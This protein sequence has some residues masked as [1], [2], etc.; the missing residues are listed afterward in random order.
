MPEQKTLTQE[1]FQ[2]LLKWLDADD[3]SAGMKY[4]TIRR[5]L[6]RL[7]V[8]RGCYEA[9][10]LADQTIDRVCSKVP[11]VVPDYVGDPAI[12]FV[13]VANKIHLEWLRHEKRERDAIYIDPKNDLPDNGREYNCLE[14]C[15][16]KLPPD[17]R[18]II[19]EYYRDEKHAKIVRR[20][21]LAENLGISMGALQ[22]KASRIRARL[23]ICVK[24][25]VAEKIK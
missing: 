20:K 4:E 12:Y 1:N 24:D 17:A 13:G 5:R 25:C 22:I 9:E 11:D 10:L 18:E 8:C 19:L 2:Q 6:I 16:E 14:S 21:E 7:F 15:L 23:L 3:E